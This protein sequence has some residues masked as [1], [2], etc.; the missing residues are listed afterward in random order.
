MLSKIFNKIKNIF[1]PV[2]E[3]HR[4]DAFIS[5]QHP[6]TVAEV[7]HWTKVYDQRQQTLSAQSFFNYT[8]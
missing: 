2:S 4:L 6:T 1:E 8:V 5:S 7:E 3:Q